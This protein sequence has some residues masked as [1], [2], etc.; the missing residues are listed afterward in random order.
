MPVTKKLS[1]GGG[2]SLIAFA[3]DEGD[4]GVAVAPLGDDPVAA[5]AAAIQEAIDDAGRPGELPDLIWL[6][7]APG[8][9]EQVLEGIASVVGTKVPVIGGSSADNDIAGQWWQFAGARDQRDGVMVIAMYPQCRFGFSFHCGYAPTTH[10]GTVTS[11]GARTIH[12]IDHEPAAVVYNRWTDGLIQSSLK[13]GNILAAS[14]F[15]PLG[16][17][18]GH[19]LNFP[20][21]ALLHPERV[22]PDGSITLFAD[23]R[24]G[25]RLTLME[26]S[27]DSLVRRAGTV[28]AG[29]INR[30]GWSE[31]R[32]AGALVVYCAGCMLGVRRRLDEVR[33]GLNWALAGRPFQTVFTFGEQG[34]FIDGANHHANLMIAV[35][36]FASAG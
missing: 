8:H 9:E 2:L 4:F 21:Y 23:V 28:A 5:A 30:E 12:T 10:V 20:Y 36:A 17:E 25:E 1:E 14:T 33:R 3:E 26:G 15:R 16:R 7:T 24:V 29:V 34:S 11:A 13:G 6:S 18:A 31:D 27:P 35:I 22:L 32:I 19:I